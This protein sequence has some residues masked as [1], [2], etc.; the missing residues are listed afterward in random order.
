MLLSLQ[1][2]FD[3]ASSVNVAAAENFYNSRAPHMKDN[4]AIAACGA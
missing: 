3:V 4:F 2:P 1:I